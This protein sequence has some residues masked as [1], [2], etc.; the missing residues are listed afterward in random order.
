M[1]FNKNLIQ[2][3]QLYYISDNSW[4]HFFYIASTKCEKYFLY[5]IHLWYVQL[6]VQFAN[7]SFMINLLYFL[8]IFRDS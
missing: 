7:I 3:M 2:Y 6:E 4:I 1:Y 5:S 8:K